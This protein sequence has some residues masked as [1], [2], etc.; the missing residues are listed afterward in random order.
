MRWSLV[1][2]VL[3]ACWHPARPSGAL[4]PASLDVTAASR[5]LANGLRVVVVDEPMAS[6][7]RVSVQLPVGSSGDPA[8]R[9]GLAHLAEHVAFESSAEG[10]TV[11]QQLQLVALEVNASTEL[12]R[13]TFWSRGWARNLG[14]MLEV[15]A[16]RLEQRCQGVSDEAFV[17]ARD[18]VA[19][20]YRTRGA[21]QIV[22]ARLSSALAPAGHPFHRDAVT[23]LASISAITKAEVCA[24]IDRHYGPS[25]AVVVI[26][27]P[28]AGEV[29]ALLDRT[30]GRV[31]HET[32]APASVAPA[33]VQPPSAVKVPL[34][35]GLV[36]LAWPKPADPAAEAQRRAALTMI[37]A[38]A[39][40]TL[41]GDVDLMELPGHLAF[42][43]E[44]GPS[45]D[46]EA[47]TEGYERALV[48]V[49][50]WFGSGLFEAARAYAAR[51]LFA[52]FEPG[53][54][55]DAYYAEAVRAGR[56]ITHAAREDFTA[57]AGMQRDDARALVRELTLEAA[58][59]VELSPTPSTETDVA[60]GFVA[61]PH[62]I[63]QPV[64]L[65][66]T[67]AAAPEPVPP[68]APTRRGIR[69]RVL[70]NG[71][72]IVLVPTGGVGVIDARLILPVGT[73]HDP[74]L[75]PVAAHA[76]DFAS[77]DDVELQQFFMA[78]GSIG[79]RTS[80]LHTTFTTRGLA[81]HADPLLTGLAFLVSR[82]DYEDAKGP[83]LEA[84]SADVI[85]ARLVW[86]SAIYGTSHPFARALAPRPRSVDKAAVQAF[87]KARYAPAGATVVV[88]GGF[89]AEAML[90]HVEAAF[91]SWRGTPA[92]TVIPAPTLSPF[93]FSQVSAG[94]VVDLRIMLPVRAGGAPDAWPRA[95]VLAQLVDDELDA[96]RNEL[97]ASY[98]LDA[99][100]VDGGAGPLVFIGG[101]IHADRAEAAFAMISARL[102]GLRDPDATASRFV[103]ARRRAADRLASIPTGH[104][105][106]GAWAELDVSRERAVGATLDD[107]EGV[108][109]LTI[110]TF[111]PDL[112]ALDVAQCALFV[113]GPGAALASAERHL[114]R[115]LVS[116]E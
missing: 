64:A 11:G 22:S 102:R 19:N 62:D 108:R 92:S 67:L 99:V 85:R 40:S 49:G 17:R 77:Y 39:A 104:A 66:A 78:G 115:A 20:E 32:V 14:A 83:P 23:S 70:A 12:D 1:V 37:Q 38:A 109:A 52:Q 13:T 7:V 9:E 16:L 59:V 97:G 2:V 71:L 90:G 33:T 34:T 98:G 101:A 91:G 26:S 80:T 6:E 10:M 86:G 43:I 25:H 79:R 54:E 103:V 29:A 73:A 74:A 35:Q 61:V 55:R 48:Q 53:A 56:D 89:E 42:V 44:P 45:A 18:I 63:A 27:G 28:V 47:V 46:V 96:V 15:E 4:P 105:E 112:A 113:R 114:G 88:S 76:L 69:E 3:V 21:T 100:V 111:A 106:V 60:P 5:T 24:F 8:A 72:R 75:A 81:A 87:R 50:Q 58:T 36:V 110:A 107:A 41:N 82:G 95:H 30:L 116:V 93:A 57:L 65:D 94:S 51:D 68:D 84:A 31:T